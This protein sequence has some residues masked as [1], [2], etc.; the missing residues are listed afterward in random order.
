MS[1]SAAE[2]GSETDIYAVF[3]RR[4]NTSVSRT[5]SRTGRS[6]SRSTYQTMS[7]DDIPTTNLRLRSRTNYNARSVSR[8]HSHAENDGRRNTGDEVKETKNNKIGTSSTHNQAEGDEKERDNEVNDTDSFVDAL[9]CN[10]LSAFSDPVDSM[11]QF[12]SI[13]DWIIPHRSRTFGMQFDED[14]ASAF[15]SP[16][17]WN[18]STDD[19]KLKMVEETQS[20]RE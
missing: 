20:N 1:V 15:P 14:S 4:T 13:D 17:F 12:P 11:V 5:S 18:I 2:V 6:I 7:N 9:D 16:D 3:R 8:E 19:M 10:D